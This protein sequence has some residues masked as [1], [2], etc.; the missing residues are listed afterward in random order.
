MTR[1]LHDPTV[2]ASLKSPILGSMIS[3]ITTF[4]ADRLFFRDVR[5]YM[6][7]ASGRS[8]SLDDCDRLPL[9]RRAI[10]GPDDWPAFATAL[11][12]LRRSPLRAIAGFERASLRWMFGIHLLGVLL[13]VTGSLVAVEILK[14]VSQPDPTGDAPLYALGL[15]LVVFVFNVVAALLHSQKIEREVLL[16]WRIQAR[17]VPYLFRTVTDIS[18]K[19]RYSY[20]TGDILNTGQTDTATLAEFFAHCCADIPVL[21]ISVFIIMG[22]LWHLL[23]AVAW[24]PL[25]I[26][27][28]QIPLSG[29]FSW[30]TSLLFGEYMERSDKRIS[31]ITEFIQGMRL[32]RYFGWGN[33]FE[34]DIDELARSQFRQEM[35]ISTAFCAAFAQS[36]YWWMVVSLGVVGGLLWFNQGLDAEK[37]FGGMWLSSILSQQLMPL[38]W[39]ASSWANSLVAARRVRELVEKPRQDEMIRPMDDGQYPDP[40][41]VAA[42]GYELRGVSFR[43]DDGT[44]PLLQNLDLD[45]APGSRLAIIGRVGSGKSVLLQ[46]LLG[47]L[48]PTKG[49]IRLIPKDHAGRLLTPIPLNSA[50]GLELLRHSLAYVPQESFVMSATVRENVPLAFSDHW[51]DWSDNTIMQALAA[52]QMSQDLQEIP[53]GIHCPIGER[54]INL[55]G[56]QRQRLSLSRSQFEDK[57]IVLL[58]DPFSA[59]DEDTEDRL[60]PAVF[61]PGERTVIWVTHRYQHLDKAD[62]VLCLGEDGEILYGTPARLRQDP[63]FVQR[64]LTV[65]RQGVNPG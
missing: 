17:L 9:V 13:A 39:F 47:E 60:A 59:V 53:G 48:L 7:Q 57:K 1:A 32:V 37:V 10:E 65:E 28:A 58:D 55:S 38:P 24:I 11:P 35:K 50:A 43:F 46:L 41:S 40:D 26:I 49:E 45:I 54:G 31:L 21:F 23:G 4:L 34:R 14:V 2:T 25:V 22:A 3:R 16:A 20:K 36:S 52:S 15:A 6:K 63:A 64:F 8:M 5:R 62:H 29:L 12:R 33:Q 42:L 61:A 27:L 19:G 51:Q 18:R 30:V 44:T 56:G